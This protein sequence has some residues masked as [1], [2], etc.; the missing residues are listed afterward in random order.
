MNSKQLLEIALR[1]GARE[2]RQS[3]KARTALVAVKRKEQA[4]IKT[5]T[6]E[7]IQ[8]L[9]NL[10]KSIPSI[11]EL[12]DF[13]KEM[14]SAEFNETELKQA[15]SQLKKTQKV[16]KRIQINESKKIFKTEKIGE[17]KKIVNQ[18]IARIDSVMKTLDKNILLISKYKRELKKYP[19]ID[20]ENP[21]VIL[22]GYPNT[23]KSTILKRLTTSKPKIAEYAF[24]TKNINLG[25]MSY[26]FFK[27][28]FLDTPGILD[29]PSEKRNS[30]EKKA[31][32]A[33][34]HLAS[35]VIYVMDAS[36]SSGFSHE[37]QLKLLKETK[38][39]F[40]NTPLLVLL[41]KCDIA[42]R[43][44]IKERQKEL[45]EFTIIEC[46][47]GKEQDLKKE[48]KKWLDKLNLKFK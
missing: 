9:K 2:A 21:I 38:K 26:K 11:N 43:K 39:Q 4:R 20:E 27:L 47:Q 30:V 46:S 41:N 19:R 14:L 7:L 36:L 28:Q 10:S 29:R 5:I 6:N 34:K 23:G 40:P 12:N 44:E 22:V 32:A 31:V 1:R 17:V 33:L 42:T 24:T 37:K 16:I 18:F 25:K 35:I 8:E 3:I 45:E 13:S 15:S 48:L